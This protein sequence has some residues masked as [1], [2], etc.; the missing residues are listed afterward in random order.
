M[1]SVVT[2]YINLTKPTIVLLFVLTGLAAMVMEGS[3][4]HDPLKMAVILIGITLTA[5]SANALNMYFDRDIDEI[6]R[7]TRKKRPLPKKEIQPK[8]ALAFGLILGVIAT[9]L[10]LFLGNPLT[11]LL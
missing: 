4:L 5:G 8:Q 7:R 9:A 2:N 1:K 3:L 10:L 6:M 11:A